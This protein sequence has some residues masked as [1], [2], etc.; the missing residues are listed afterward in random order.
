MSK[1]ERSRMYMN[2]SIEIYDFLEKME[3]VQKEAGK[4]FDLNF[5]SEELH[6]QIEIAIE[7]YIEDHEELADDYESHY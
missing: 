6:Q 3:K 7:D 4:K 5:E 2:L 1:S